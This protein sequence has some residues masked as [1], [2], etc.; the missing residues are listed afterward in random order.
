MATQIAELLPGYVASR[1]NIVQKIAELRAEQEM[2]HHQLRLSFMEQ[3]LEYP[4]WLHA[5]IDKYIASDDGTRRDFLNTL[6]ELMQYASPT[7]LIADQ[8]KIEAEQ[9]ARREGQI[10]LDLTTWVS[11][12]NSISFAID[13][14]LKYAQD[15]NVDGVEDIRREARSFEKNRVKPIDYIEDLAAK[16]S[17]LENA[18]GV[19]FGEFD[20]DAAIGEGHS[21]AN[22]DDI[23]VSILGF[24]RRQQQIIRMITL[25]GKSY[26]EIAEELGITKDSVAEH[27][28]QARKKAQH[29]KHK[30]GIQHAF[31]DVLM[32]AEIQ[33]TSMAQN[34][35]GT[36]AQR[37]KEQL[38]E[39]V[40]LDD[41]IS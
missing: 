22:T 4:E 9:G 16:D 18:L 27:V 17:L 12:R 36:K 7:T 13:S 32:D 3:K 20:L 25:E 41:L 40:T 26:S 38:G 29:L 19:L 34:V 33:G 31:R 23:T 5:E 15:K 10:R 24:S 14:M 39:Q 6:I 21:A 30:Q 8:L 35:L 2:I 28:S 1:L 37:V 11:M